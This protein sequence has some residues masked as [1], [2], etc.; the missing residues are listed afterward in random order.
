M[1]RVNTRSR[2]LTP[3]QK[4][5]LENI[6]ATSI[7]LLFPQ[8]G[9][10]DFL[11]FPQCFNPSQEEFLFLCYIYFIVCKMHLIWTCL[12]YCRLVKS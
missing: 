9:Y 2:L 8:C 12:K 7:F 1:E 6:L 3:L 11:L 10:Q 4:E 5:A